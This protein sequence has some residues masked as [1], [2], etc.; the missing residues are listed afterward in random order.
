[1]SS[2]YQVVEHLIPQRCTTSLQ[3]LNTFH[4]LLS[5]PFDCLP[6]ANF[7]YLALMKKML[8]GDPTTVLGG[9]ETSLHRLLL[10]DASLTGSTLEHVLK[11]NAT[12]CIHWRKIEAVDIILIER[13]RPRKGV[14]ME[15]P[16]GWCGRRVVRGWHRVQGVRRIPLGWLCEEEHY[17]KR[18]RYIVTVRVVQSRKSV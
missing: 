18:S 17:V 13:R 6:T 14:V 1:M 8:L 12:G 16:S 5:G 4:L 11:S 7:C 15:R 2:T 3:A 10:L 9:S